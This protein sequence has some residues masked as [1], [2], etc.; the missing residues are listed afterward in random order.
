L[1]AIDFAQHLYTPLLYLGSKDLTIKPVALNEGERDFLLDLKA[2]HTN[3]P[4]LFADGELYV[5]RNMTRGKG[6]GFF[7]AGNFYPDFILWMLVGDRQL[8]TFIDPKGISRLEG[9]TDPKISFFETIKDIE[10][11]MADESVVLNSFI[12]SNTSYDS[13]AHWGLSKEELEARHVMFQKDDR[14]RY[15]S[16]I[17]RKI[18][19]KEPSS[20]ILKGR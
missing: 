2:A 5:M 15:I 8:V 6:I 7:E 14:H 4:E 19:I 11:E 10:R 18:R 17:V 1:Q 3:Q 13:I 20:T 12:V 16:E 9:Y